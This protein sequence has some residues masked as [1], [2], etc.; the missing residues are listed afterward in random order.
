MAGKKGM[1]AAR[2]LAQRA[3]K[4]ISRGG[5]AAKPDGFARNEPDALATWQDGY[6]ESLTVRN[7]SPE[8]IEGRRDA[9]K[10]FNAW[11]H[12]RTLTR[13]GE[14]TRPILES[15]QRWLWH[16]ERANGKRLGISTQ[17]SKLG[18]LKDWF[19][20]L[21]RQNVLLSNPASELELPRMEKRLPAEALSLREV[22]T[23][24]AV[25]S[26]SDPLGVRDR[27]ILEVFYSCGLRRAELARLEITDVNRDRRTLRIRQGKG[28]KDRVIPIGQRAL[29]WAER[30]LSQ[31]RPCLCLDTRQNARGIRGQLLTLDV[32]VRCQELTPSFCP[33]ILTPSF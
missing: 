13:A 3:Q 14:I 10:T 20:W 7:Y 31:V 16:Y 30:Y 27:A 8:T 24:L 21:V 6:L 26:I 4:E 12:E 32:S 18:A 15:Y 2:L 29:A 28:N 17:R 5:N 33:V 11:A 1:A 22:E 25:P 19:S 23:I 9:L